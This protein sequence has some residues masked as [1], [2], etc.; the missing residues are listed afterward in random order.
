MEQRKMQRGILSNAAYSAAVLAGFCFPRTTAAE[1][2]AEPIPQS[3]YFPAKP[4]PEPIDR[5]FSAP[6]LLSHK[7]EAEGVTLAVD[8]KALELFSELGP[9]LRQNRKPPAE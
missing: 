1:Q 3:E 7:F 4:V 6:K 5:I 9:Y 2:V 8:S